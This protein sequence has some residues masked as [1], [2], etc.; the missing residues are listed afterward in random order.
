MF[1]NKNHS[2]AEISTREWG[3]GNHPQEEE[4]CDRLPDLAGAEGS[5]NCIRIQGREFRCLW[6]GAVVQLIKVSSV[7]AQNEVPIKVKAW[8][9]VVTAI[10]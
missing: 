7:C 3:T 6:Q 8:R 10:T 4:T 2:D 9:S 1:A 5:S